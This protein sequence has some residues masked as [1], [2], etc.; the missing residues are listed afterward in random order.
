MQRLLLDPKEALVMAIYDYTAQNPRE[1]TLQR[2]E[3]YYIIDN[4]EERWWMVQDKNG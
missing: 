3:E 2:N 1:L 4:S